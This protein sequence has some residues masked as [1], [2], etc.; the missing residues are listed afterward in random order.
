M[1]FFVI[2]LLIILVI[3]LLPKYIEPNIIH[4]ITT[5]EERDYIKNK[6]KKSISPSTVGDAKILDL[7]Y[8]CSETAWLD[9]NDPIVSKIIKRCFQYLPNTVSIDKCKDLQVV[10][11]TPGGY[12]KPH[13]DR[14]KNEPRLYTFLISIDDDYEGGETVFPNLNTTYKLKNGDALFFHTTDNYGS[15][16]PKAL[17]GGTPVKSGEKWVANIW[18]Y[19]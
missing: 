6:A 13:Q 17:H 10:R 15:I 1:T 18:I 8:R 4:N 3:Y 5:Q 2:I 14:I 16:T 7:S 19:D 9:K 11:Y 12:Y